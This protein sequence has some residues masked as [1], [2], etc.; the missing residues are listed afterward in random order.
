MKTGYAAAFWRARTATLHLEGIDQ[1]AS[2]KR[3]Q[4]FRHHMQG[5]PLCTFNLGFSI[6]K[7]ISR[8]CLSFFLH[9]SIFLDA[10]SLQSISLLIIES[11]KPFV[12]HTFELLMCEK[13]LFSKQFQ[14]AFDNIF[15]KKKL[16]KKD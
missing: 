9:L 12:N 13:I 1:V 7:S 8:K 16:K 14:V 15:I 6:F 11:G 3:L 2:K 4:L 10:I 5:I